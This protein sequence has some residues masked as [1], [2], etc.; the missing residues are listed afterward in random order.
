MHFKKATKQKQTFLT[1]K[2]SLQHM[3]VF[4]Q[5]YDLYEIKYITVLRNLLYR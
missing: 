4:Q 3:Y 1:L 5:E 2:G